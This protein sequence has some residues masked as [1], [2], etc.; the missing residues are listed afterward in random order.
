MVR[1]LWSGCRALMSLMRLFE[2][3]CVEEVISQGERLSALCQNYQVER[4][5]IRS[6]YFCF[7]ISSGDPQRSE[8]N[9]LTFTISI[10]GSGQL[11]AKQ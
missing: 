2:W 7:T 5:F 8:D 1:F 4:N 10:H 3:R 9:G 11:P 6:Y